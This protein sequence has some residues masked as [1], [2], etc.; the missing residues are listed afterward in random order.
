[1]D[2]EALSN[3]YK[4]ISDSWFP[5]NPI[6]FKKIKNAS[7]S[8]VYEKNPGTLKK[9]IKSDYALF[10]FCVR[11]LAKSL[12]NPNH[13]SLNTT[14]PST[15][16][17]G[18]NLDLCK[19]F[20]ETHQSAISVHTMNSVTGPQ[21]NRMQQ[22]MVSACTA[23]SLSSTFEIEPELAYST[24]LFR[25]LG[26]TLIAWNYPNVYAKV[27]SS[28]EK[29][30]NPVLALSKI[31][32]FSPS[33]L[34]VKIAREW[35]LIPEIRAALGEKVKV[36]DDALSTVDN[37]I[38]VCEIGEQFAEITSQ[39]DSIR[40]CKTMAVQEAR[41]ELRELMGE[42]AFALLLNKL[43]DS[44]LTYSQFAPK[45]FP[46]SIDEKESSP[47]KKLG[48]P[49]FKVDV[50]TQNPYIKRCPPQLQGLLK[51]LYN[52]MDSLETSQ[53]NVKR[54]TKE[55]IPQAGFKKGC[56]YLVDTT[57]FTLFP[58]LA[59]GDWKLDDFSAVHYLIQS[60]SDNIVAAAYKSNITLSHELSLANGQKAHS[61][62]GLL[63]SFERA[64]VL[65]LEAGRD[66]TGQAG[67]D[68][69]LCFKALRQAL[70]DCLKLS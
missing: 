24:A 3:N 52:D 33:M 15:L 54:L 7:N 60:S 27:F 6:I 57:A 34:G 50:L 8:G 63:G 37:L 20:I 11:R 35:G 66:N 65:Y 61:F 22:A 23:E 14:N 55:I 32:G 19:E 29:S 46:A 62:A 68:L 67:Q 53:E 58:R 70:T 25:Q 31:L 38:K 18:S 40:S 47:K 30:E 2:N 51:S 64:G 45:I 1:M 41:D 42:N 28:E 26:L 39:A 21:A 9:H 12:S 5:V 59:I 16:L 48:S 17:D 44:L 4:R 13:G 36:G 43:E 10:T 69:L 49:E 56:V